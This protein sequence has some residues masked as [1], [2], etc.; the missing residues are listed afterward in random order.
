MKPLIL[1]TFLLLCPLVMQCASTP[2]P[3]QAE[4]EEVKE[5]DSA[6]MFDSPTLLDERSPF[7][8]A[9]QGLSYRNQRPRIDKG[10]PQAEMLRKGI[11]AIQRKQYDIGREYLETLI[12]KYPLSKEAVEAAM[13]MADSYY[14]EGSYPES[15]VAYQEFIRLH[16]THADIQRLYL[17]VALAYFNQVPKAVDRDLSSSH[18]AIEAFGVFIQRYPTHADVD[19]AKRGIKICRRKL[20]DREMK[21]AK[22]YLKKQEWRASLLRLQTILDTYPQLGLDEEALYQLARSYTNLGDIAMA[23]KYTQTLLDRFPESPYNSQLSR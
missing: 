14:E 7:G 22:F 1:S 16:P 18:Q 12:S 23:E 4:I 15:I 20:A 21:I 2:E 19:K 17:Q 13:V 5:A 3:A 9:G 8:S 6:S 11:R 10:L